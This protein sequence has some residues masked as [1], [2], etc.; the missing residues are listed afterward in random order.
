[1]RLNYIYLSGTDTLLTN[2]LHIIKTDITLT[3]YIES[4][5]SILKLNTTAVSYTHLRA[6]ET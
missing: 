6:H 1:M 5:L 2:A 3:R 4:N